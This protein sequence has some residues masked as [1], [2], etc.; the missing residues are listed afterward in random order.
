VVV[1]QPGIA[2]QVQGA[3]WWEVEKE[4]K[5]KKEQDALKNR[6]EEERVALLLLSKW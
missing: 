3:P 4:K 5:R 1:T 2:Q 6:Y